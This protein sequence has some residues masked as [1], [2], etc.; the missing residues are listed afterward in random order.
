VIAHIPYVGCFLAGF[1]VGGLW[2]TIVLC[3][4]VP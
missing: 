2:G 3:E 4:G 1:T